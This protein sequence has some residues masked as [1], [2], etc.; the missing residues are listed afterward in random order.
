[1]KI[2]IL[3]VSNRFCHPKPLF[4]KAQKCAAMSLWQLSHIDLSSVLRV[5]LC[6]CSLFPLPRPMMM[7]SA[8]IWV[9]VRT[10]SSSASYYLPLPPYS[11]SG[12]SHAGLSRGKET[13]LQDTGDTGSYRHTQS[14]AV[15][16]S[17]PS[18]QQRSALVCCAVF[19]AIKCLIFP[20]NIAGYLILPAELHCIMLYTLGGFGKK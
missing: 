5:W 3:N 7:I 12:D 9:G 17:I 18:I 13:Q 14:Y 8:D 11:G 20:E 15:F 10:L 2:W 19:T 16:S 6:D 4:L 1:M